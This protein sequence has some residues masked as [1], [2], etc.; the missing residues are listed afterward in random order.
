[1]QNL[2]VHVTEL[3]LGLG[4]VCGYVGGSSESSLAVVWVVQL[5]SV[6]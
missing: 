5:A 4:F 2:F 1:M 6:A 3:L